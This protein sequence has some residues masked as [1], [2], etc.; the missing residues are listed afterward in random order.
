VFDANDWFANSRNLGQAPRR[1]NNFGGTFEG[2]ILKDKTF[3]FASY[4]GLRLRQPMTAITDVPSLNAR[5]SAPDSARAFLNA[6]PLPNGGAT[7]NGFA[8]F[9]AAFANPARHDVASIRLDH[10]L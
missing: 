3:F 4:E 8:E 10:A 5:Q 2:P 7:A 6:F 1:L 9:A